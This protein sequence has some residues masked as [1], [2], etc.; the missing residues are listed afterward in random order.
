[1]DVRYVQEQTIPETEVIIIPAT[2]SPKEKKN[3]ALHRGYRKQ[4]KL[5]I[6]RDIRRCRYNRCYGKKTR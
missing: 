2:K 3:R 5:E 6:R 1:M 4:S